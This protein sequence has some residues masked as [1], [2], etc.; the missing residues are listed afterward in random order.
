VSADKA[1][2]KATSEAREADK[3]AAEA[4]TEAEEATKKAQAMEFDDTKKAHRVR[5]KQ[6]VRHIPV[7]VTPQVHLK[8][9]LHY[10][11]T[12]LSQHKMITPQEQQLMQSFFI[13]HGSTLLSQLAQ[14]DPDATWHSKG[15]VQQEQYEMDRKRP[16][17]LSQEWGSKNLK[18]NTVVADFMHDAL[19]HQKS[20]TQLLRPGAQQAIG[21]FGSNYKLPLSFAPDKS[22]PL[23]KEPSMSTDLGESGN[24]DQN[25]QQTVNGAWS[26]MIGVGE[27]EDTD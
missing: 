2:A 4:E 1:S 3:E 27:M 13:K 22:R 11:R 6:A 26:G 14:V 23:H 17:R 10:L 8:S 15:V 24:S 5:G 16:D 19:S 21:V 20:Q 9:L 18:G 12:A 25:E 7:M